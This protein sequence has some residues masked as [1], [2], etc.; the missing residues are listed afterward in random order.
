MLY[1]KKKREEKS[2][3]RPPKPACQPQCM[4][5]H[6]AGLGSKSSYCPTAFPRHHSKLSENEPKMRGEI[7]RT[8]KA[9]QMCAPFRREEMGER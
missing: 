4:E 8:I 7:Y 3:E 1:R 9:S 6:P 5:S 2:L